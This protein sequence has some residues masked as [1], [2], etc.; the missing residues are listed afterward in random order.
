LNKNLV[1]LFRVLGILLLLLIIMLI[2]TYF[3]IQ[4]PKVQTKLVHYYTTK[5]SKDW[6]TKVEIGD[7]EVDFFKA[8][9]VNDV[10]IEDQ[11]GD[12][13]FYASKLE[14][15]ASLFQPLKRNFSLNNSKFHDVVVRLKRSQTDSLYN[16]NHILNSTS[17]ES[18]D[19]N[20]KNK[21][22]SSL[23]IEDI[24]FVN[25][26]LY[27]EDSVKYKITSIKTEEL[28]TNFNTFKLDKQKISADFISASK[29]II[30]LINMD[31][32]DYDL[33]E[34]ETFTLPDGWEINVDKLSI[35]DG[36]FIKKGKPKKPGKDAV[37][38]FNY[39]HWD[40]FNLEAEKLIGKDGQLDL[41]IK[42]MTFKDK[43]GFEVDEFSAHGHINSDDIELNNLKVK[44]L[45]SNLDGDLSMNYR[46]FSNFKDFEKQIGLDVKVNQIHLEPREFQLLFGTDILK[47]SITISGDLKGKVNNLSA[48]NFSM[49]YDNGTVIKGDIDARGLPALQDTFF[50]AKVDELALTQYGLQEIMGKK[51]VPEQIK[52]LGNMS[53]EGDFVGYISDLIAF[54]DLKTEIGDVFLDIKYSDSANKQPEYSGY[55]STSDF[56]VGYW[57]EKMLT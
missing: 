40:P 9:V 2:A 34:D 27:V 14:T 35:I 24:T 47:E 8:V 11:I 3:L 46:A 18:K 54:G 19:K 43:T 48:Q 49:V 1:I 6:N 50:D 13:L 45:N 22:P 4:R 39:Y 12:T 37:F 44:M 21:K 38:A 17:K 36:E 20:S 7:V 51:Q 28:K 33:R 23:S 15:K 29:P 25:L 10:Y 52:R 41:D 30:S 32:F 5:L 26:D 16:F 42:S 31:D 53:F 57:L 55:V 56:Q